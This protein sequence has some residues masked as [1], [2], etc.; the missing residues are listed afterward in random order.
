MEFAPGGTSLTFHLALNL[1]RTR[2]HGRQLWAVAGKMDLYLR[3]CR[4]LV[5]IAVTSARVKT[6]TPLSLA[7]NGVHD[8]RV[9]GL[10]PS[11]FTLAT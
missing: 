5:G 10:E 11:T 6:K 3:T 8:E 4:A 1:A 2:V 7:D 9:K